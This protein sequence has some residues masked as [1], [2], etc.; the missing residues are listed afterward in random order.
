ME[1]ER[2]YKLHVKMCTR[3][4]PKP[5]KPEPQNNDW[6]IVRAKVIKA[7]DSDDSLELEYGQLTLVG[8]MVA[9]EPGA[10]YLVYVTKGWNEKFNKIQYDIQYSQEVREFRTKQQIEDFLEMFITPRQIKAL[11]QVSDEPLKLIDEHNVEELCKAAGIGAATAERIISRYEACKDYGPAYGELGKMGI[12]K[13]LIDKL[14]SFYSSADTVLDIIK[15]R[16]YMLADDIK[17]I[18]F[19]KADEIALKNGFDRHDIERVKAFIIYTMND[20]ANNVGSTYISY[21]Y[22]MDKIDEIIGRDTPQDTIDDALDFLIDNKIIWCNDKVFEDGTVETTLALKRYYDIEKEL[23][24]HIR[25]LI[26]APSNITLSDKEI[27][28][29]IKDQEKRQGWCYTDTQK[30][31]VKVIADNNVVIIRGYGGCVDCDTEY[32]NGYEWKRIADYEEG[33]MVLQWHTD[34]HADLVKP[35]EYIKKPEETLYHFETKYGLDQCLSL[36]HRVVYESCKGKLKVEPFA[37]VIRQHNTNKNGFNGKFYTTFDYEGLGIDKTDDEIRLQIAYM[38]DGS[39]NK[40]NDS[41]WCSMRLKKKRKQERIEM[42]LEKCEVPYEMKYE[43][44]TGFNIYKFYAPNREKEFESYWYQCNKHQFEVVCDEVLKWDGSTTSG[45]CRFGSISKKTI[46]FVQ[47]AFATI[48]MRSSVQ[49]DKRVGQPITGKP[50]D[51]DYRHIHQCYGL[52]FTKKNKCGI[53]G[54]CDRPGKESEGTKILPYKTKDGY[55]YCFSVPTTML[56]LRRNGKIFITGNT[57]KS[58]TVAGLLSCLDDE[59]HFEQC[60]LSGKASVN[61]TDITG[62]EG[63]TI[64]R[65]LKYNPSQGFTYSESKPLD[66]NMVIL[67]EGSMVDISLALS[68]FQA[69]PT[70]A[71]LVILGDTN[72]L[73]PIGAG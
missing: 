53:S 68:L 8:N 35:L 72:Q 23:A 55:K 36:E 52:N 62:I 61:L 2:V 20:V 4:Y 67:D 45:K 65:L 39:F 32:F 16:P 33:E 27:N 48:G 63:K 21:T 46:D 57:G 6:Q 66:T 1:E 25:R 73:P 38:A 43:E 56:V 12:T 29:K 5:N 40:N 71:K 31:G 3:W 44:S 50:A 10:V 51:K 42:L 22:L 13:A 59:Y 64:H 11:Y 47:F 34:G 9:M 58:S 54:P 60:A 14:I 19:L 17:G 49:L 7:I 26:D 15:N 24:H 37:E 70:G 28:E 69:I 30:Y 41:T 18:G